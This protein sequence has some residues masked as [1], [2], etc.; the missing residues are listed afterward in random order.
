MSIQWYYADAKNQQQGPVEASWI[1]NAFKQ[2]SIAAGTLVWREGLAAWVPLS[3]IARELGLVV[4]GTPALPPAWT[5]PTGPRI[6]KPTS[7][8]T[9]VIVVVVLGIGFI[10]V[11][12]ILAAIALPAYQ[13][14][15]VRAKISGAMVQVSPVKVQV[16][17]FFATEN[18]CPSNGQ[19]DIG[20]PESYASTALA[21]IHVGSVGKG[22]TCSIR[23]TFNSL[24]ARDTE[25][26]QLLMSMDGKMHWQYSSDM[27]TKY[28]PT[29]IRQAMSQ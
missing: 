8:S 18:R 26:K 7:S 20:E 15:T 21:A 11:M 23:L 24:G 25:G 22:G 17:E 13:D 2:G 10:A 5:A 27:P 16:A 3:Q 9:W 29:S 28:L 12:G 6:S 1:A 14:Y 19:G 4:V